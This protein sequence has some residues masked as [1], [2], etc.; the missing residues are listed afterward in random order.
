MSTTPDLDFDEIE[1]RIERIRNGFL[2]CAVKRTDH[3]GIWSQKAF[4]ETE[5]DVLAALPAAYVEAK[6]L[7]REIGRED[8]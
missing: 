4:H 2:L 6:L 5:A 3:C 7:T 8:F 1:L